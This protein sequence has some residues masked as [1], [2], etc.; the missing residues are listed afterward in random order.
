M[1]IKLFIL[2]GI[3]AV[4]LM[5]ALYI[6]SS[7]K[8][9]NHAS[10]KI[11]VSPAT[12]R[13]LAPLKPDG[14]ID[15]IAALNQRFGEGV[16]PENNSV[17]LLWQALGPNAVD[18]AIREQ[19][20]KMLGV[21]APSPNIDLLK[22]L[23]VGVSSPDSRQ[24]GGRSGQSHAVMLI[25][26]LITD[27]SERPWS[28]A[29]FPQLAAWFAA[30]DASLELLLKGSLRPRYYSPLISTDKRP[31][32]A[33]TATTFLPAVNV[34]RQAA[35]VLV[36]RG[37]LRI[38]TRQVEKAIQD[39]LACHRLARLAGQSPSVLES[40]VAISV[41]SFANR[42]DLSI[43]EQDG[44]TAEKSRQFSN[45]LKGLAAMPDIG[46]KIDLM[47]RFSVLDIIAVLDE[48]QTL[49]V[50]AIG[51]N[52]FRLADDFDLAKEVDRVDLNLVLRRANEW[53]DRSVQAC[54]QPTV[55]GR[56][57]A[58]SDFNRSMKT[59][60]DELKAAEAHLNAMGDDELSH[61][62]ADKLVASNYSGTALQITAK[63]RV[64]EQVDL[65][66]VALALAAYRAEKKSNPAKLADLVPNYIDAIPND[67]FSGQELHYAR[68]ETGYLLY[69]VGPNGIDDGGADCE[70]DPNADDIAVRASRKPPDNTRPMP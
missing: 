39:S 60:G 20:F 63:D 24:S 19:Y 10:D 58:C 30:N 67:M 49:K 32:V 36:A 13:I 53:I 23:E 8:V 12:T 55:L 62:C 38:G 3:A 6:T 29:E 31:N 1:R 43:A 65:V 14:H 27:G 64:L 46:Q 2:I 28:A 68:A 18:A 5:T 57:A 40:L 42:L 56:K 35:R 37:M 51:Q 11:A 69:S 70:S 26:Q 54:R 21:Q 9:R 4:A 45:A 34:M 33:S 52:G 48:K 41:D 16:T 44:L 47:E 61:W 59:M 50:S 66:Q 25:D 7:R 15:Y 22:S 17:A